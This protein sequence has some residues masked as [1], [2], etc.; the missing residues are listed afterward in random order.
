MTVPV[1]TFLQKI[2]MVIVPCKEP[3]FDELSLILGLL[4]C[5]NLLLTEFVPYCTPLSSLLLVQPSE[6][7]DLNGWV[8]L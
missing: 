3:E 6:E 2:L 4:Y 7:P 1:A 8:G 5:A